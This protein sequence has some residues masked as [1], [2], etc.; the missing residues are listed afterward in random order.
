[1]SLRP[2][3][4]VENPYAEIPA[5]KTQLKELD[6]M[7]V[8]RSPAGGGLNQDLTEKVDLCSGL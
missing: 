7:R 2:E 1:M 5:G 4:R 3:T 6:S 8:Q